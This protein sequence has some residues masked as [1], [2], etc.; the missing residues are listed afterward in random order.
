MWIVCRMVAV[1]ETPPVPT[2]PSASFFKHDSHVSKVL[3]NL[4]LVHPVVRDVVHRHIHRVCHPK[5]I[6]WKYY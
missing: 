3:F 4:T 5:G 1:N 6:Y 2:V